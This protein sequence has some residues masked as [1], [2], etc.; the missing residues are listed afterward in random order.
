[1]N[2]WRS[3]LNASPAPQYPQNPQNEGAGGVFEHIAD[4]AQGKQDPVSVIPSHGWV[5]TEGS[6]DRLWWI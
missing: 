6:E 5:Q 1:M 4:I 2:D 3:I